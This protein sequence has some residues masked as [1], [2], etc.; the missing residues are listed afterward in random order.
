MLGQII[1]HMLVSKSKMDIKCRKTMA[2]E[3]QDISMGTEN[4][5]I[6]DSF[7][8]A[9]M[10]SKLR[11]I[12]S[13]SEG[14]LKISNAEDGSYKVNVGI[15]FNM[16]VDQKQCYDMSRRNLNLGSSVVSTNSKMMAV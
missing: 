6:V 16:K 8:D 14:K 5:K 9:I 15:F 1:K 12:K 10:Y 3:V 11:F 2:L 7:K 4:Q 13:M